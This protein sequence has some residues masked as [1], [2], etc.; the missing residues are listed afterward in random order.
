MST[1][2]GDLFRPMCARSVAVQGELLPAD[3][4]RD[5]PR[6]CPC[7]HW[8]PGEVCMACGQRMAAPGRHPDLPGQGQ[9][10]GG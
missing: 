8:T 1:W 7:G 3:D 4:V 9:L 6:R 10:F 2:Q 5:R